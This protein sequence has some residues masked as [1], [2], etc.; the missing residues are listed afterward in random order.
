MLMTPHADCSVSL[1]PLPS[2]VVFQWD[3]RSTSRSGEYHVAKLLLYVYHEGPLV[4]C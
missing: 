3:Q 4:G 2:I 1:Y